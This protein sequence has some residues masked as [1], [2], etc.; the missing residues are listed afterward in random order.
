VDYDLHSN[1]YLFLPNGKLNFFSKLKCNFNIRIRIRGATNL[2]CGPAP[3]LDTLKIT[4]FDVS[5]RINIVQFTK[6]SLTTKIFCLKNFFKSVLNKGA[7]AV[8]RIFG[9]GCGRQFN[10]GSS[11]PAPNLFCR[12]CNYEYL[13]TLDKAP[14]FKKT[15]P[16]PVLQ[17]KDFSKDKMN[18]PFSESYIC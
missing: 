18:I 9:S 13:I 3:A 6:S 16:V 12:L 2:N 11:A 14:P 10:F 15:Y 4:F 17:E 7:G 5:N 1:L 8:I